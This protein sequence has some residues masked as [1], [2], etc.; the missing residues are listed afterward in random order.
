MEMPSSEEMKVMYVAIGVCPFC[1]S[2]L[3]EDRTNGIREWKHCFS[4]HSDFYT[5]GDPAH[6]CIKEGP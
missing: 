6:A 5:K 3:S 1:R 4:C 2:T